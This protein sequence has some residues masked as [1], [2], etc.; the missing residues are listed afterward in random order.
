MVDDAQRSPGTPTFAQ[1][2]RQH[3]IAAAMS[4]EA[5]AERAGLSARAISDLE[6]G[7]KTRPYLETVRMLADALD[8]TLLARSELARAAR[9]Q[10]PLV[11]GKLPEPTPS[12]LRGVIPLIT[13]T[14]L[15]GRDDDIA[16]VANHLLRA[17]QRE[18]PDGVW[19][20]DLTAV[21]DPA[22][23]PSEI[24]QAVGL[25]ESGGATILH[26]LVNFLRG[27]RTLLVLD[28]F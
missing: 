2:L 4:Q 8:L 17:V 20:I 9:P 15:V 27:K 13:Q 19:F 25:S 22:L 5:L 6:R 23:V 11:P 1:L 21:T 3:R 7:V 12:G 26:Q 24:A 16:Q 18:Y 14:T 28:N 10:S